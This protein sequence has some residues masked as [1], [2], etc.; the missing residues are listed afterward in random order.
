[1][2]KRRPGLSIAAAMFVLLAGCSSSPPA[3]GSGNGGSNGSSSGQDDPAAVAKKK[4][5]QA[6]PSRPPANNRAEV[7]PWVEKAH[8]KVTWPDRYKLTPDAIYTR[9]M[10]PAK[11][12]KFVEQ[13][14]V[15]MV[16]IWNVCAWTLQLIDDTKGRKP[17]DQ[18]LAALGKLA[19]GDYKQMLD[20][21]ISEARLGGIT[22]ATQFASAND[23]GKG[24]TG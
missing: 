15:D 21:M 20:P 19:D 10:E 6:N 3:K 13:D 14:A 16:T 22:S 1:M 23:C 2:L 11:D 9:F 7:L 5:E 17:V 12:V 18:D 24:F 4:E 8:T